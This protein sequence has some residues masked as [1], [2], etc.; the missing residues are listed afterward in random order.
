VR[1]LGPVQAEPGQ[2]LAPDTGTQGSYVTVEV[3]YQ[4]QSEAPSAGG[5]P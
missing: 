5:K 1:S 3:E 2:P 4:H